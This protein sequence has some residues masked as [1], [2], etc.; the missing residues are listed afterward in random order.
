MAVEPRGAAVQ[1][2]GPEN[3]GDSAGKI[4]SGRVNGTTARR[5]VV[6]RLLCPQQNRPTLSVSAVASAQVCRKKGMVVA[7]AKA[8]GQLASFCGNH[9]LSTS[10]SGEAF[11]DCGGQRYTVARDTPK[12][13]A[14]SPAG[15]PRT[16]AIWSSG[17]FRRGRPSVV[18]CA[19]ARASPAFTR[20][21]I[22]HRSNC[23]MAPS[24]CSCSRPA[25][26]VA[27]IPSLRL[28]N[29]TPSACNSSSNRITGGGDCA[30]AD[31]VASR[32]PRRSCG[33]SRR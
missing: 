7:N 18:P 19:F 23:A 4:W 24:A 1:Q 25:A 27:S 15:S 8:A 20:S 3:R 30:R 31:P 33:A 6:E 13:A 12:L 14:A 32:E 5:L 26:V 10:R 28:T 9:R 21:A 29:A 2:T 17:G 16:A 11:R 22:R